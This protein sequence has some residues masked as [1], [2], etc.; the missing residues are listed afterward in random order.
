MPV[1]VLEE[2]GER[3]P[4]RSLGLCL[5]Y[6]TDTIRLIRCLQTLLDTLTVTQDSQVI[7][8]SNF[9]MPYLSVFSKFSFL[10]PVESLLWLLLGARHV[11]KY[12]WLYPRQS[13]VI[14]KLRQRFRPSLQ[15]LV[16]LLTRSSVC[17]TSLS[18][19]CSLF[20]LLCLV[21]CDSFRF[22]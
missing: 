15:T 16:L 5:L 20:C 6:I 19:W 12:Y 11:E 13:F 4:E 22:Y 18:S 2:L 17:H 1:S 14:S 7:I 10:F 9:C 3:R 8:D 21:F